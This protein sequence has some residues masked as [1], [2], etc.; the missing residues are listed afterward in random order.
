MVRQKHKQVRVVEK[1]AR[2]W[3]NKLETGV[4]HPGDWREW[5][6]SDAL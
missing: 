6:G 5:P 1:E 3:L 2:A 4:A